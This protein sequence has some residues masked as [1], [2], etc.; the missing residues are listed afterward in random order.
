VAIAAVGAVVAASF[1]SRLEDEVGDQANRP[2]VAAAVEAAKDQPLAAVEVQGVPEEVQASVRDAAE[3]A[4]VGAFRVGVGIATAL[5]A[6]G[7]VLGLVGIQN[8]RRRV[9][10]ADC[11]GGQLAGHPREGT[12]QSPCDWDQHAQAQ[13]AP[14]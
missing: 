8:P 4:S 10:A 7:G 11:P 14:A 6:L 5:V 2:E 1:G 13:E 12:K 9:S 3:D